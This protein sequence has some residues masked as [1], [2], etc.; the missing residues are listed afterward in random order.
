M[1]PLCAEGV[2]RGPPDG[3]IQMH[4]LR[5]F[6]PGSVEGDDS[7]QHAGERGCSAGAAE[8][9][10]GVEQGSGSSSISGITWSM[11]GNTVCIPSY[12]AEALPPPTLL[13]DGERNS[14]G[15]AGAGPTSLRMQWVKPDC[16]PVQ[17]FAIRLKE[18]D[19]S[20][21]TVYEGHPGGSFSQ[22]DT[23]HLITNPGAAPPP[24][25]APSPGNTGQSFS[26]IIGAVMRT[27]RS[28]IHH[29]ADNCGNGNL[30]DMCEHQH[31][32]TD[33]WLSLRVD[34]SSAIDQV[35]VYNWHHGWL[36]S[37]INPFHV[38]VGDS[39]GKGLQHVPNSNHAASSS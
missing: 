4:A 13:A 2:P 22:S 24:S 14:F 32:F 23:L 10:S 6:S 12:V 36:W 7:K 38:Y 3:C 39:Y 33:P 21:V 9:A 25:P 35:D 15:P 29:T 28:T 5:A 8:Q 27:P 30:F 31:S 20:W 19:G 16:D 37:R 18:G 1:P 17:R 11:F 26:T 34:A